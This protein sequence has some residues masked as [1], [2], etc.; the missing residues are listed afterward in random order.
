MQK[1]NTVL[2]RIFSCFLISSEWTLSERDGGG[3]SGGHAVTAL[4]RPKCAPLRSGP[5]PVL[6]HTGPNESPR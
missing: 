6:L 1:L 5:G 4:A 2:F 3:L